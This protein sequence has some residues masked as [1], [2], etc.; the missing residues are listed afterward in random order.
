MS[1]SCPACKST[2]LE[3]A[4]VMSA[5]LQPVRA[6]ALRKALAAAEIKAR[7]CMDCGAIDRLRADPKTLKKM[8]GDKAK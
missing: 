4:A 3:E 8:L 6:S 5:G 1:E 7:V 2:N